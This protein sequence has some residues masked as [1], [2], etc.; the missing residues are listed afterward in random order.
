MADTVATQV[1]QD[2]A[3]KMVVLLTNV[4]DG[5]GEAAVK[6]VDASDYLATTFTI[7]RIHY[8]TSGMA[9]RLLFDATTDALAWTI[10]TDSVGTF[11][12][13]TFGGIPDPKATGFTGDILLTTVG[14][15]AADTYSIILELR[16]S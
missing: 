13:T 5:T 10:A 8:A 7:E 6:K 3:T 16:K 14:H 9:V 12:F 15:T 4:S 11:D 2:G 1:I